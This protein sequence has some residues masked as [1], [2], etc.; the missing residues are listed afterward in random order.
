MLVGT[1]PDMFL[2]FSLCFIFILKTFDISMF[3]HDNLTSVRILF[4]EK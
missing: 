2:A 3:T 4:D 1:N